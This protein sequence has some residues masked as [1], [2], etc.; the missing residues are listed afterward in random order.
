MPEG[1]KTMKLGDVLGVQNG[2]AFDSNRFSDHEGVPLI[3]IRDLKDGCK[4]ILRYNGD[5]DERYLVNAGD[6]LIGMDGEFRCYM[7]RGERAL[8]NQRV[9]RLVNFA[10]DIE[11]E[12]VAFGINGFLKQIEDATPF[13]TVKHLSAKSIKAIEFAFPGRDEQRRIVSRIKA[14]MERVEEI[15]GDASLMS[16]EIDAVF[17]A[18]LNERFTEIL[19]AYRSQSLEEVADIRGGGSLP[20]GTETDQGDQSVLLVKVGDMNM[21]GNERVMC[22]ARE[23]LA[24]AEAGRSAIPEGAVVLPKRGGAIATNKK[25]LLGR[26]A[27]IDPNLMAVVAHPD[28]LSADYLY[29]WSLTLDLAT[30]SNGGVIPQLNRKDLAPLQVPVP[31]L[32][33][34]QRIVESLQRSEA[35]CGQLRSEFDEAQAERKQLRESILR[36]AFTGEL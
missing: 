31:P 18:I 34:Q 9:C 4:T 26:P 15:E 1:W 11:P 5:F 29:Y 32:D 23:F 13:V 36:K 14:C 25:R 20:K 17:P 19:A 3:R 7:W 21:E 35:Y 27:L 12:F 6:L 30:L 10:D 22:I 33:A 2:F 24:R 16:S 28:A 8:L